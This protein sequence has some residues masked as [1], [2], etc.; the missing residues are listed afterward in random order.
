MK[1]K[2]LYIICCMLIM[3]AV[4]GAG[5]T[6]AYSKNIAATISGKVASIDLEKP[7]LIVLSEGAGADINP[8]E[9]SVS[10]TDTTIIKK[11]SGLANLAD[12]LIGQ[13]VTV[14]YQADDANQN[15]ATDITVK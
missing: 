15:I 6:V 5:I 14:K 2:K 11:G 1:K 12:I 9:V 8:K 4:L 10:I 13:K 7:S 3:A